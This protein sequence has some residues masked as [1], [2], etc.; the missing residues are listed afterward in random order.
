MFVFSIALIALT[1]EPLLQMCESRY[2]DI[3]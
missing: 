2:G 3:I 1:N